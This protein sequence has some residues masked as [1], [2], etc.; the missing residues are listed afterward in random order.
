MYSSFTIAKISKRETRMHSGEE[1][2]G[3]EQGN[4]DQDRRQLY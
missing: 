4:P 3:E 2:Q 1:E